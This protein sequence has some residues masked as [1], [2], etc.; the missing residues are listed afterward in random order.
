MP[1]IVAEISRFCLMMQFEY[2]NPMEEISPSRAQ[3][4]SFLTAPI[5]SVLY[6]RSMMAS[7]NLS[8]E[9]GLSGTL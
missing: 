5:S 8:H 6:Q 4:S 1:V 2:I 3:Q 7:H 9:F